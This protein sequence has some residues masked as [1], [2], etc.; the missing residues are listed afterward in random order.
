ML[1][2]IL[3][4]IVI[5]AVDQ[6]SKLFIEKT[7]CLGE[8][9][10]VIK[11]IFHISLVHNTGAAFGIFKRQTGFFVV[12]SFIAIVLILLT[13]KSSSFK[14]QSCISQI[15]LN[16]ILGGA[17]GNLIDRLRLGFVVDFLD[18]RVWPVFNIADSCV[19]IGAILLALSLFRRNN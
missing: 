10:P 14:R 7:F 18:F 3:V 6:I 5:V 13:I 12:T 17:L 11:N 9:L 19:S 16:L 4:P 2:W 1:S 15:A 8:S